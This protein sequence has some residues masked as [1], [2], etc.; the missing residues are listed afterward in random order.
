[1]MSLRLAPFWS[2]RR[3]SA[4]AEM[5]LVTPLLLVLMFGAMELGKYFWDQHIVVKAVRD[6]A[7]FAA[8]Q[9]MTAMPCT[10]SIDSTAETRIKNLVRTGTADGTGSA[11]LYYWT[12][13]ATITVSVSCY[14]NSGG[15]GSTTVY[16]GVYNSMANVPRVTVSASVPYTPLVGGIGLEVA[17]LE[18]N[19]SNQAAVMGI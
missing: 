11:R 5:A 19:A 15:G 16:A 10:G 3:G 12:N 7:R 17:G 4:A 13:P 1:M 8:R 18:L 14:D 2:D 9:S 6:G